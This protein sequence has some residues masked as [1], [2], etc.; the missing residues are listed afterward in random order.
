M[1][2]SGK[3]I[4]AF[5]GLLLTGS[6]IGLLLGLLIGHYFDRGMG[7]FQ[8]FMHSA[9]R[10]TRTRDVFFKTTFQ[11]MGHIAKADGRVSE[12]EIVMARQVMQQ[13]YL[14]ASMKQRAIAYFNEGKATTFDC[15]AALA[16]LQSVCG[17]HQSLLHLFVDIQSRF[18]Q[19][20]GGIR[21]AQAVLLQKI[22]KTLNFRAHQ[23]SYQRTGFGQQ[24]GR[25]ARDELSD[26][27]QVLGLKRP[28]TAT[29]VKKSYR[30]LMSQNHPD[31]MIAKGLP[32]EM[33]KLAT[34]KTQKI[35]A[36]YDL[37]CRQKDF[38]AG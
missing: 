2:L 26:A 23:Y 25:S 13:M 6:I 16:E 27:Y 35:Q 30:H 29:Q 38:Q 31:K 4:G 11:V 14:S 1:R 21:P 22:M 12:A 19:A 5:C 17:A 34:E 20:D 8:P 37:I 15:T 10:I 18:A 36:A 32:E 7:R 3:L 33:V 28:S 9:G 24:P